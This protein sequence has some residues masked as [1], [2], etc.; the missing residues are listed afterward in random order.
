MRIRRMIVRAV[1]KIRGVDAYALLR[2]RSNAHIPVASLALYMNMPYRVITDWEFEYA[3]IPKAQYEKAMK[4]LRECLKEREK[5][6][7][8]EFM[9]SPVWRD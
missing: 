5:L 1:N 9:E 6:E 2:T 8:K 3:A 7:R 4:Y